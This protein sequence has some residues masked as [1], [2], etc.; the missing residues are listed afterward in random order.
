[1]EDRQN[2]NSSRTIFKPKAI[3]YTVYKKTRGTAPLSTICF[4]I[5]CYGTGRVKGHRAR[6]QGQHARG[7]GS[8]N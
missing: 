3:P 6:G 8:T 5:L 1:M 7:Q 2:K 4:N